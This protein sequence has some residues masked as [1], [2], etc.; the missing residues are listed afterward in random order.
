MV[1]KIVFLLASSISV[2]DRKLKC[3][4]KRWVMGFR[5]PPGG[6]MAQAK[7]MSTM[8]LNVRAENMRKCVMYS[9]GMFFSSLSDMV[10]VFPVPVGP[11]HST[12]AAH[13]GT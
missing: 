9:A 10:R 1:E 13:A 3:R 6:P 8:C 12:C 7:L 11:M 4:V 5:P 2:K